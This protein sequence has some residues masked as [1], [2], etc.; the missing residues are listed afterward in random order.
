MT[1]FWRNWL[2]LWCWAAGLFGAVLA[3]GGL[4]ATSGPAFALLSLQYGA[5]VAADAPVRY[6]T[7]LV[8]AVTMGWAA[9]MFFAIRA[10]D[11][12]GTRGADIWRGLI[13]AMA[14]WYVVDSALSIATGFAL[15]AVSNTLLVVL[16]LI[17]VL[18]TGVLRTA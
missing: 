1:D 18:R 4:P 6:A 7:A 16:F 15:N 2:T 14:F 9:T 10:A 17:P 11:R 12:L 8:G 5:P 3:L 13:W